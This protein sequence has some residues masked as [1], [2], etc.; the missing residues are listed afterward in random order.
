[1]PTVEL[2]KKRVI[3]TI[4]TELTDEQLEHEISML[5]TDVESVSTSKINVEVF[6]DR[7]D[8]LYEEGLAKNLKG[9]IEE[10]T[11]LK[12]YEINKEE[13]FEAETEEPEARPVAAAAVVKGLTVNEKLLESLMQLQEKLHVT[14]GRRRK[15]AAIGLHNLDP[16][17]FPVKYRGVSKSFSFHPL[18]AEEEMTARKV[19]EEHPKGQKFAHLLEEYKK[20]PAWID[21]NGMLLSLPPIINGKQTQVTPG[22]N[23]FFLDV[24][25]YDKKIV[26][27]T[28]NIM[29]TA[30]A[31]MGGKIHEVRL[32]G[33]TFPDLT[34]DK[35]TI[36]KDYVNRLLGKNFSEDEIRKELEKMRF[37]TTEEI[38]FVPCYRT[39]VLHQIDLVED[40]AI[41]HG[42]EN[43]EPEI[44]ELRGLGS[45]SKS[46]FFEKI[47]NSTMTSLG[48]IECKNYHLTNEKTLI[49]KMGRKKQP[50]VKATNPVNENY[51]ALRNMLTPGLLKTLSN[52]TH[53]SFPQEVFETGRVIKRED[54]KI[55]ESKRL[56]AILSGPKTGFT[57][58][59]ALANSLFSQLGLNYELTRTQKPFL[60]KGRAAKI[61]VKGKE[62]GWMGEIHPKVLTNFD[63]PHPAV[64]TELRLAALNVK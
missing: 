11:G 36:E 53:H 56:A 58:I 8:L 20:F 45:E 37:G 47:I 3:K 14:H 40:I 63:L 57:K 51:D 23:E 34:P 59:K 62:I 24:T 26:M 12:E 48:L 27:Q 2:D 10:E 35:M 16:I 19:L 30:M 50:L 55:K 42:Y 38:V 5:G 6:P 46:T 17:T 33:E 32:N 39:D 31:D 15:E 9:L 22:D 4:K 28:L 61:S 60:L 49:Q 64:G 43:F 25:G 18:Q 7:P 29:A 52:N 41:A 44:P 21:D 13:S 1:M 54:G